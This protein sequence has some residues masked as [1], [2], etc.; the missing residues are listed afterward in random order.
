MSP[1]RKVDAD[2]QNFFDVVPKPPRRW[3]LPIIAVLAS[4][5]IAAAITASSLLWN[6]HDAGRDVAIETA[7][8]LG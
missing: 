6:A 3:G 2:V 8:A 5:L 7:D 1:R 4:L